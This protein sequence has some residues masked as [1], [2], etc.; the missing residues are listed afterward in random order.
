[1]VVGFIVSQPLPARFGRTVMHSGEAIAV[2]GLV[3]LS[4][5]IRQAGDG[6]GVWQLAPALA[7]LGLGF[8]MTMAPYFD[9]AL[10]GVDERDSGSASGVLSSVQQLGG[11]IG[12]GALGT[13]FWHTLA[14]TG[15]TTPVAGFRD[16]AS[17]AL[18]LAAA[19]LAAAFV[20]TFLLPE[21]ARPD[22][23]GH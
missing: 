3:G 11:A 5:T 16:A 23:A 9:I 2:A 22:T 19:L 6:L 14:S 21:R 15:A 1:M 18:F 10:A 7:A 8:G 4:L 13:L 20:R 17:S 12:V